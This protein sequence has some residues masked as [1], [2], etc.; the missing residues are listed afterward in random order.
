V[1]DFGR[2]EDGRPYVAMELLRGRDLQQEL[3]RSGSIEPYRAVDIVVQALDGL[4][5]AHAAGI[6]HRDVKLENLFLCE[7]GTVKILDFGIAK[8]TGSD[9]RSQTG[10]V[11]GTPRMM[12]P[13]QLSFG[14]ID[15][16]TD[17]YAAGLALYELVTGRGPFDDARG[18][19]SALRLAHCSRVPPRPSV[20][21]RVPERIE[22][23][24]LRA[25]A[26]SPADRFV[27]AAQ[28]AEALREVRG[29]RR[30]VRGRAPT[31]LPSDPEEDTTDVC[32]PPA[33]SSD[34]ASAPSSS[35]A[36]ISK[37]HVLAAPSASRPPSSSTSKRRALATPS[38]ASRPASS[39]ISERGDLATRSK[40][41]APFERVGLAIG[42]FAS[43]VAL[44]VAAAAFFLV[45]HDVRTSPFSESLRTCQP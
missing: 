19:I 9:V 4:E 28:M 7:D 30:R 16:R 24:I 11:V 12:S 38:S 42:F 40:R 32:P 25:L 21:A 3:A 13:E 17:V 37:R 8:V 15:P 33:P 26:K 14:E 39:S 20:F 27:S 2:A 44:V 18:S 23:L 10:V 1:F 36:A 6:I 5:A 45:R 29:E 22:R 43:L 35:D 34:V 41:L 31:P